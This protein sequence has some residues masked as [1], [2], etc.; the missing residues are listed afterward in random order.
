LKKVS[1]EIKQLYDETSGDRR[2][3]MLYDKLVK[4]ILEEAKLESELL[5]SRQQ[6]E[7]SIK[8]QEKLKQESAHEKNAK[9]FLE[10]YS[11][12]LRNKHNKIIEDAQKNSEEERKKRIQISTAFQA[13]LTQN[14]KKLEEVSYQRTEYSK[15]NEMLREKLKELM[16][17]VEE[18]DKTFGS[19]VEEKTKELEQYKSKLDLKPSEEENKLREELEE[20]K[21]KFEDFQN[22]LTESN[23]HFSSFKKDMDAKNKKLKKIVKDNSDLKK[24]YSESQETIKSL[25][26]EL[27]SLEKNKKKLESDI[28]KLGDLKTKLSNP[29]N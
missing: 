12:E 19:M 4:E 9:Q 2:V 6:L 28:V 23:Q 14:S 15:Y 22:S 25:S 3:Q 10:S 20:Y 17:F 26:E 27:E 8:D 21:K 18:R 7:T 5:I 24:K 16:G 1:A 11:N 13:D 29:I